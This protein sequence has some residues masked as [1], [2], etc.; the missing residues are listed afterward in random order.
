REPGAA[1][2]HGSGAGAAAFAVLTDSEERIA[3]L[4]GEGA[5]NQEVA[6]RMFLSV[7]TIEASLTRIYRKLGIRSRTQLSSWLSSAYGLSD[8][9]WPPASPHA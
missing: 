8:G 3:V 1:P 7:K 6:A 5:T 2:G 4:V 9:P